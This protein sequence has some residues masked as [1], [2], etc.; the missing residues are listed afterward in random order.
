[1]E[2]G[3]YASHGYYG[4]NGLATSA[5]LNYPGG[6]AVDASGNVYV[7]DTSN[8]V[9]R[10]VS[11]MTGIITTVAGSGTYYM[12]YYSGESGPATN[13]WLNNPGGVAVDASGNI[14]IADTYD[15]RIE[16]V[17]VTTGIITTVAGSLGYSSSYGLGGYA[18]D[19]GPAIGPP[20][21]VM[22]NGPFGVTLDASGNLYIAE[23]W[24]Q[25][26]PQ[27]HVLNLTS[28]RPDAFRA[29]VDMSVPFSSRD[30]GNS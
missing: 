18:G 16:K 30:A 4:D 2:G 7:A 25:S 22:L 15:G 17:S 1:M 24:K 23:F 21:T 26:H 6:V 19:N 14:Y 20:T 12:Q 11:A 29:V 5:G 27:G 10:K 9:I 8:C 3:G 28:V 13:A